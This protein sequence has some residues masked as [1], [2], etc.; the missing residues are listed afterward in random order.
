MSYRVNESLREKLGR[1][2]VIYGG[3]SSE[4]PVSLKS[5][6]AV[7]NALN[8][9]GVDAFGIDLYGEKNNLSPVSQLENEKFDRA[10]LIL[11]GPGGEDGTLQGLLEMIGKPYTGSGV[12]ASAIGMDKLRTKQL[13]IGAGIPTPTFALLDGN[14]EL[15]QV[16]EKLGFPMIVKPA[17][18]GSSIGMSKVSNLEQLKQALATAGKYDRCV[19]A[20]RWMSG[21]E[22][23]V[24]VLNGR[25]LPAIKLVTDHEFYDFNAKYLSTNTQYQFETGLSE[26]K[27]NE[28]KALAEIAFSSLGC[29]GWGRVDVMQDENGEF[30]LL[31]INTA[32]GMTDH[33]LVPMSAAEAGIPFE[34]LVVEILTSE[35]D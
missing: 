8:Q 18:E 28:L 33:S 34:R 20:E 22:Y 17:H 12:A 31:E 24:A 15:D 9:A 13:W 26:N 23:T 29:K 4:R 35:L 14:V 10:F 32:P 30:Q 2:A 11:H 25:A 19:I 1:V 7:L 21:D 3:N 27:L 6:A 5:G 16:A